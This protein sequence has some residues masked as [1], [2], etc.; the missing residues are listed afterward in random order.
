VQVRPYHPTDRDVVQSLG[1][2]LTEGVAPWRDPVKVGD[3]VAGWVRG[4]LDQATSDTCGAF[5][6]SDGEQVVGFVTV[7]EQRHWSG[8]T[9]AYIGELVV[10]VDAEGR[11][12]GRELVGAAEQWAVGR[13]H[14]RITLETGAANH[15]ARSFYA[16]LGYAEEQVQLTR[17]CATDDRPVHQRD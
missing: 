8:D 10:A 12:V 9:D 1:R 3:A 11:G 16:S 7:T 4:S 5:V 2:R 17:Q 6:A 14:R 15:A 13:G